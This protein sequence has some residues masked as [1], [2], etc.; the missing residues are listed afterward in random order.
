MSSVEIALS[1]VGAFYVLAGLFVA[2]QMMMET[3]LDRALAGLTM[4]PTPWADRLRGRWMLGI[5]AS[6]FAGG[7]LL[8]ALSV[9]ALPAF[10]AGAAAQGVYL[11]H[12]APRIIDPE[13]PPDQAGRRGA[14]NAFLINLAATAFVAWAAAAGHL[15]WPG[16][17]P[18]PAA[19]AGAAF[20][21]FAAYHMTKMREPPGWRSGLLAD[22]LRP[23]A[24]EVLPDRVRL[25]V[26]PFVLPFA[27][28]DTGRVVPQSLAESVFGQALVA[29]ILE[30]EEAYLAT[31]PPRKRTGGFA[32]Q[33]AAARHEAEGRA[34]AERMAVVIGPERVTYA[35]VGTLFPAAPERTYTRPRRIRVSADYG[36]HPLW[37]MDEAYS[38]NLDPAVL[39]LSPALVADL[40]GWAERFD[41]ALDWDNPGAVR[42]EDGYV[43]R[44]DAEGRALAQRLARELARQGRDVQVFVRTQEAGVVEVTGGPPDDLPPAPA[45]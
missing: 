35:A 13:E 19:I 29:D 3:F 28:D 16:D 31:I 44:H 45:A 1:L 10:L 34:L 20:G 22:P 9:L 32:D 36:C 21:A 38:G 27:D 30:W 5:A 8:L 42:E 24:R 14:R 33:E 12:A 7:V 39:G 37:S 2:R 11:G 17:D 18:W 6:V 26:R 15:R 25:M 23:E 40:G 41:D 43:T 4:K